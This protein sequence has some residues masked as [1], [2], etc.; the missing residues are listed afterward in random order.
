MIFYESEIEQI[1]LELFRDEGG[2]R[3]VWQYAPT[4]IKYSL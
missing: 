4:R 2:V 1:T 3:G